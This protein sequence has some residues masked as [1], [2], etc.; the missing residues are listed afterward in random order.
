MYI[1]PATHGAEAL[2]TDIPVPATLINAHKM[3]PGNIQLVDALKVLMN[4]CPSSREMSAVASLITIRMKFAWSQQTWWA[5]GCLQATRAEANGSVSVCCSAAAGKQAPS[6]QVT[7]QLRYRPLKAAPWSQRW[8]H[9]SHWNSCPVHRSCYGSALPYIHCTREQQRATTPTLALCLTHKVRSR[10][11]DCGAEQTPEY[12]IYLY[13]SL[14][15]SVVRLHLTVEL[16]LKHLGNNLHIMSTTAPLLS[17]PSFP[18][19]CRA[20][21]LHS[22][23]HSKMCLS[24]IFLSSWN[25]FN[26]GT[27]TPTPS[28]AA[29]RN[30]AGEHG[31]LGNLPLA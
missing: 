12:N 19:Q 11:G 7:D 20:S 5:G 10:P 2:R 8:M 3:G 30:A 24:C 31:L 18:L 29:G 16:G 26:S 15:K 6:C 22:I 23:L 4:V 14:L 17:L 25:S 28:Y 21:W 13:I 9:S 1:S 27:L